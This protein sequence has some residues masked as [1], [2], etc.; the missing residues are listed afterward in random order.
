[1]KFEPADLLITNEIKNGITNE[2]DYSTRREQL[3]NLAYFLLKIESGEQDL[4]MHNVADEQEYVQ[5]VNYFSLDFQQDIVAVSGTDTIPCALYQFENAYGITPYIN[6]SLAFPGEFMDANK[7]NDVEI[8]VY[9]RI[10]QN[11]ILKFSYA[12]NAF[13]DLPELTIE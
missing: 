10:F 3:G 6:I 1:M 2:Q 5:R 12:E 7:N 8:L 11:G 9:D 4:L 13:H